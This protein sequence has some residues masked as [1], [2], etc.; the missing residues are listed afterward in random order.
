VSLDDLRGVLSSLPITGYEIR[1]EKVSRG[2]IAG[3][4][5]DIR[6]S[7]EH[8]PHRH[9]S[10]VLAIIEDSGLPDRVKERGSAVFR[11]LAEAEAAVHGATVESVHFHEVG[12]VDAICDV[13]GTVYCLDALGI[14]R[15]YASPL[16]VGT[17]WVEAAHGR[18]PVPVPATSALLKDTPY[19]QVD[20]GC[21]LLTPTGAALAVTLAEGFGPAPAM[22]V[23]STGY[24]AG[25]RDLDT[26]PNLLRLV[27]GDADAQEL[28]GDRVMV[29]ETNLDDCTGEALGYVSRRLMKE[30]AL[31][32]FLTA[33]QMKK[34]RPGTMLTV[35]C[36]PEQASRLAEIV[37]VETGTL[38]IRR[39]LTSRYTLERD[40]VDV[41]T[42]LGTVRV[43]VGRLAGRIVSMA[44]EYEDCIRL[45][46]EAGV[47][48][49]EVQALARAAAAEAGLARSGPGSRGSE[50]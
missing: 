3:T 1:S 46:G 48:L 18:L 8:Q 5:V 25:T 36:K 27:V 49:S 40:V 22:T 50:G 32:V 13:V 37:F 43:K 30:G 10:H 42:T 29:L 7:D 28:P 44:P 20:S 21:E 16:T 31:D 17:G 2:G 19:R 39:Q 41:A 15:L 34:Q 9:L 12:A 35:I 6:L 14:Q 33:V 26:Q 23:V 45:A 11:R 38:G 24:G 47:T 4:H